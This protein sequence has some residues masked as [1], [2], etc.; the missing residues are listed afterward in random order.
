VSGAGPRAR[1]VPQPP[2]VHAVPELGVPA[3]PRGPGT[4]EAR[5]VAVAGTI[6]QVAV[7]GTIRVA[8]LARAVIRA[9]GRGAGTTRAIHSRKPGPHGAAGH[10]VM[11]TPASG[12]T[13]RQQEI[14]DA[15]DPVSARGRTEARDQTRVLARGGEAAPGLRPADERAAGEQ[16]AADGLRPAG[17]RGPAAVPGQRGGRQVAPARDPG[18][19]AALAP[20][21]QAECGRKATW[22]RRPAGVQG[23]GLAAPGTPGQVG[24]APRM[25]SLAGVV[26]VP[27]AGAVPRGRASAQ[28]RQRAPGRAGAVPGMRDRAGTAPWALGRTGAV[29]CRSRTA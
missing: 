17:E 8:A 9:A 4:R 14:K 16:A 1:A 29:L 24:A 21:R 10:G 7:A 2:A 15:R 20:R 18:Y 11:R 6:R 13:G 23:P 27:R 12:R 3:V 26:P 22:G 5:Q 25:P 28:A 19:G